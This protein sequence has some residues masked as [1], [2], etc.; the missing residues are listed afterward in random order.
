MCAGKKVLKKT[1]KKILFYVFDVQL[2]K[3][4]VY[5]FY[6]SLPKS[7]ATRA[8]RCKCSTTL[9]KLFKLLNGDYICEQNI[10]ILTVYC[11]TQ[12]GFKLSLSLS[13]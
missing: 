5:V 1:K 7:P 2:T 9:R 12:K 11:C 10:L 3:V 13:F 6:F 4:V 8:R